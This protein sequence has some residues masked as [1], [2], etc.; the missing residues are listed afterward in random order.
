VARPPTRPLFPGSHDAFATSTNGSTRPDGRTYPNGG[1]SSGHRRDILALVDLPG[2][3]RLVRVLLADD[4]RLFAEALRA[5]LLE[6][7]RIDVVGHA[8]DGAEAVTL[9]QALAPDVVLMDLAMPWMGGIE[10]T[11]KIREA[12]SSTCVLIVAG[13]ASSA[14]IRRAVEAGAV[15][16][17]GKDSLES[18]VVGAIIELAALAAVQHR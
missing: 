11:R 5:L 13:N 9:V 18:D 7:E 17:L 12:F 15:G 14:D 8:V 6:D 1:W 16:Y 3:E 2:D 4:D 10:A